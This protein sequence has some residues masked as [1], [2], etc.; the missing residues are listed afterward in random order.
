MEAIAETLDSVTS[1]FDRV[2]ELKAFDDTKAGVKG[3]VDAG[4]EK[5]PQIFVLPQNN[6]NKT[7]DHIDKVNFSIPVIDLQGI[8]NNSRLHQEIVEKIRHA[9]ETWGFF[10]VVNHGI[11]VSVLEEMLS[12]IQRFNEQDTEVKKQFYTRDVSRKIVYNSNFDLYTA[13]AANW[14]D[15]FFCFMAPNPPTPEELPDSC[16]YMI[17]NRVRY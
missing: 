3:L 17:R 16:R 6:T 15:T 2:R 10:Q 13:P 4:V 9:S 11:P 8:G 12:G 1:N 7:D 14:R 5:I